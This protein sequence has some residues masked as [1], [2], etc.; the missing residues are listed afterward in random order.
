MEFL[1]VGPLEF[2]LIVLI[3]FLILGPKEIQKTGKAIGKG[4]NKLVKS[5]TWKTVRDASEKV[6]SLPNELMRDAGIED[7]QKSLG[8]NQILNGKKPQKPANSQ[9]GDSW[10]PDPTAPKEEATGTPSDNTAKIDPPKN[11]TGEAK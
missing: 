4:L 10:I 9:D 5:D 8:A 1:G 7:L 6:K 11:D 3:A 2:L